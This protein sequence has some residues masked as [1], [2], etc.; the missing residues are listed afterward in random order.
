MG[1]LQLSRWQGMSRLCSVLA[2]GAWP[3]SCLGMGGRPSLA[4]GWDIWNSIASP[5]PSPALTAP[6]F[7]TWCLVTSLSQAPGH[8]HTCQAVSQGHPA[9]AGRAVTYSSWGETFLRDA[10]LYHTSLKYVNQVFSRSRDYTENQ[11]VTC[12]DVSS[13]IRDRFIWQGG[14][15]IFCTIEILN[16]NQ[17]KFMIL[18]IMLLSVSRFLLCL[19]KNFFLLASLTLG[20]IFWYSPEKIYCKLSD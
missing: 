17:L 4:M 2:A 6:A 1:D 3:R 11:I 15:V 19:P 13:E 5:A 20:S 12:N 16:I 7:L 14:S 9:Q 10:S 8:H 18:F